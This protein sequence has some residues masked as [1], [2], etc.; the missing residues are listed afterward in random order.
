MHN[1]ANSCRNWLQAANMQATQ[2]VTAESG[3]MR[4]L[5]LAVLQPVTHELTPQSM[6]QLVVVPGS[7]GDMQHSAY[8]RPDWQLLV[9]SWLGRTATQQLHDHLQV[10]ES[11]AGCTFF[12][13]HADECEKL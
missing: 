4:S 6:L 7:F 5:R 13:V 9:Y 11:L 1:M 10:K 8:E 12:L 3:C 2:S